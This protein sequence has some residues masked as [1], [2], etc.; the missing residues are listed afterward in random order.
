[1]C[2]TKLGRATFTSRL[3]NGNARYCAEH[4]RSES[5]EGCV[6]GI[7]L[8][9]RSR[10]GVE[11]SQVASDKVAGQIYRWRLVTGVAEEAV[12]EE[13]EATEEGAVAEAGTS[14][15]F[16]LR[17]GSS[18]TCCLCGSSSEALKPPV[19][20]LHTNCCSSHIHIWINKSWSSTAHFLMSIKQELA[21]ATKFV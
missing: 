17:L 16:P 6:H 10:I 19:R 5:A 14:P 7:T 20:T 9:E 12:V 8:F 4:K 15:F 21:E 3:V 11:Q 2:Q 13:E 1:M 18:F